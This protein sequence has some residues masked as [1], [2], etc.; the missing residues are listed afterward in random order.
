MLGEGT[1]LN[2]HEAWSRRS[3]YKYDPFSDTLSV[4]ELEIEVWITRRWL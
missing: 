2:A 4:G 1:N 3:K